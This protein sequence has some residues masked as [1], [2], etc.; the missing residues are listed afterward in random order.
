MRI[1]KDILKRL[2]KKITNYS[3][4][5]TEPCSVTRFLQ[6]NKLWMDVVMELNKV[7]HL[8]CVDVYIHTY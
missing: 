7:L 8:M 4:E 2:L 5:C 3:S 1:S 6:M